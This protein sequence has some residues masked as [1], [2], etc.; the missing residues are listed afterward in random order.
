MVSGIK[1]S[2]KRSFFWPVAS[3]I[4]ETKTCLHG[5][6]KTFAIEDSIPKENLEI[7]AAV[8]VTL[9]HFITG[10]LSYPFAIYS[11]IKI[12]RNEKHWKFWPT[13]A[14]KTKNS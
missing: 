4:L 10:V 13:T 11:S 12:P 8:K 6:S 1:L 9:K 3:Y 14:E 5:W 2:P 7:H